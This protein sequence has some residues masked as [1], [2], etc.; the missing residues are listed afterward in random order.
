MY[1]RLAA[2]RRSAVQPAPTVINH[3]LRPQDLHVRFDAAAARF[4][5]R[6]PDERALSFPIWLRD[7]RLTELT[8]PIIPE[9]PTPP[10]RA[11]PFPTI[12]HRSVL[13]NYITK[14]ARR[15]RLGADESLFAEPKAL[16]RAAVNWRLNRLP[17]RKP[18]PVCGEPFNRGHINACNLFQ[19][20][21][22][23]ARYAPISARHRH[24]LVASG[25]RPDS[26]NIL[27]AM[28]NRGDRDAF[29]R[30]WN[31][32]FD[33]DD[34]EFAQ[35]DPDAPREAPGP[36]HDRPI[37]HPTIDA[38]L[39][40][41]TPAEGAPDDVLGRDDRGGA[42]GLDA[43]PAIDPGGPANW[44]AREAPGGAYVPREADPGGPS[45]WWER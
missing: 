31:R 26:Y 43:P 13:A 16:S 36:P 42:R 18:C 14:S 15:G 45:N 20:D 35:L 12:R 44:W 11:R 21:P 7:D 38:P 30:C 29:R 8:T 6:F 3:L 37:I 10:Q 22:A 2:L 19:D 9:P 28:L 23:Y 1:G 24:Q 41:A 34:R 33:P 25:R 39:D 40:H 17:P 27:D 4:Q 5:E 32:I